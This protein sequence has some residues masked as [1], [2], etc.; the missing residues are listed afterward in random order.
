[1][2]VAVTLSPVSCGTDMVVVQAGQESLLQQAKLVEPI[3][4]G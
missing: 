2:E 1:M 3:I 4:P